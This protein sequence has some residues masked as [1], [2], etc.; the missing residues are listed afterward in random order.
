LDSFA[1]PQ[2]VDH[3][4]VR[5]RDTA[6]VI[7][8]RELD[9]S[10]SGIP[11]VRPPHADSSTMPVPTG[12]TRS[13]PCD[14]SAVLRSYVVACLSRFERVTLS[15]ATGDCFHVQ[16]TT[17]GGAWGVPRCASCRSWL[18]RSGT[19]TTVATTI[20]SA[21]SRLRSEA[22]PAGPERPH[23]AIAGRRGGQGLSHGSLLTW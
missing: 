20:R 19:R 5:G 10:A 8:V 6:Q 1:H 22:H 12:G 9:R 14:E 3:E 16:S 18:G 23:R 7:S 11:R 17:S 2:V 13:G 15:T 4:V 21:S